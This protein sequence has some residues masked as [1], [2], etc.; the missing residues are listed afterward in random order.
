MT[1]SARSNARQ[2]MAAG[3]RSSRS[4]WPQLL[5]VQARANRS[6]GAVARGLVQRTR[7]VRQGVLLKTLTAALVCCQSH[8]APATR[9]RRRLAAC[10]TLARAWRKACL[11]AV[12]ARPTADRLCSLALRWN[13]STAPRAIRGHRV[14]LCFIIY[15]SPHTCFVA[16]R[17][18]GIT[19]AARWSYHGQ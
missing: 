11:G 10:K 15:L 4:R 17:R 2:P 18:A 7:A 6:R 19:S 5:Q 12:L 1:S 14:P 8:A 13:A 3:R 9:R 16:R